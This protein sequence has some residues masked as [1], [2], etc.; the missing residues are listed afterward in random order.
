MRSMARLVTTIENNHAVTPEQVA[1]AREQ[2]NRM[3]D[4]AA[5]LSFVPLY[6][7]GATIAFRRLC[8]RFSSNERHVGLVA[9]CVASVAVSFLG[10]QSGQLWLSVWEAVRVGNGHMSSFRAATQNP[11]SHQHVGALF[12]G[13]VLLF[14]LVAL[15]SYRAAPDDEHGLGDAVAPHGVLLR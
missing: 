9:T 11:W 7:L 2:R 6:V 4:L 10:L 1:V 5:T 3:F 15:F 14:W 12:F 8:R 13:G